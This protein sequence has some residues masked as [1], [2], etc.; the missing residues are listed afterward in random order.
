MH[1]T[2]GDKMVAI[3]IN[4]PALGDTIAAIP[5]LRRL[6]QAY[7]NKK[8]T[9]FSSKPFL[10][11]GHPLVHEVKKLEDSTEGYHVY[12]TFSNLLTGRKQMGDEHVEFRYSN[13]DLR[14][15]HAVSLG[16]TLTEA[17]MEM[18]L[19]IEK[20]RE[21]PFKDYVIIHPT[22]T[23]P[24]RTWA[25]EKWQA[26]VDMLNDAGIP[27]V[28]VG[29]DSKEGGT[30][31]TQKPVMDIN[32]RLGANLLN[33]PTND[34]AELRWMMNHRARAVVTMDSGILHIAGT[35]NV[36]IIQLS[37]SIDYR[38]RAPYR[39]G[40]Q[41][42]KYTYV[43]GGCEMCS[44]DMAS[45]V[46]EHGTIHGVPP[47]I[48][49]MKGKHFDE[50]HPTVDQVFNTVMDLDYQPLDYTPSRKTL[51]D[52]E[53]VKYNIRLVHLLLEDDLD[54]NRQERS[55]K[56]VKELERRG[57]EY[58]QV[59]NKRWTEQPPRETFARP[60]DFDR[61]P[62]RPSHYGN[63]RAFSD[64][65]KQYF[66]EDIDAIILCE[67][68]LKLLEDTDQIVD[69][70]NRAYR[71]TQEHG[72]DYFSLGDKYLL[73]SKVLISNTLE[74]H[75][76][77]E[78]IDRAIGTQ[79]IMFPQNIR[80]YLL[81]VYE[82]APWDCVDLFLNH[83]FQGKKKIG[84]FSTSPTSQW[85]GVSSIEGV[86]RVY[87]SRTKLLYLTPHLSTGGM[88]QFVLTRLLALKEQEDYDI[89][90]VEYT[91]YSN[92][93]T[94]QRD[95]IIDLLE[96]RFHT[97]GYLN[98]KDVTTRSNDL[99]NLIIEL[100][101]D[102]IHIDECPEAFDSFNKLSAGFMEWLYRPDQHWRIVETCHNIWFKGADKKFEP[103]A[104]LF[105]TP[106][107]PANSFK[108]NQAHKAVIEYPI[109]DL[110]PTVDQ[111][112]AAKAELN[113]DPDK[114]HILNIGLW[115]H[116]KNQAE[117]VNIAKI[118]NERFPGKYQF[119]FVGNQASNFQDYWQPIMY[120]LPDNIKVWG[121]RQDTDIFYT[122]SD[123]FLFNSTW[124]CNPLVLREAIGYGLLTFSRNLPQYL[125]MFT[126]Y[127]VEL[128]DSLQQNVDIIL[129]YL[130]SKDILQVDF[131]PP[132]NEL[133]RFG[134]EHL[135]EYRQLATLPKRRHIT[136]PASL[137][138]EFKYGLKLYCDSLTVGDWH[139][140][141]IVD[142][143]V[144]YKA[145]GLQEGYWYSPSPKWWAAWQVKVYRDGEIYQT[146]N[147]D[148][149]GQEVLVNFESSSLGDTLSWMGQM[150]AYKEQTGIKKLWVRTYKNWLFDHDWYSQHGIELIDTHD[151]TAQI[152]ISVGVFYSN[153]EPW[154]KDRHP[155]DWRHQPLGKIVTDQLGIDYVELRPKIAQQFQKTR[156][157][158]QKQIVI[159]T[160]STAQAKYW[161]NPHG[162]LEL[163]QWHMDQGIKVLHASKEGGGPIGSEQLPES[164]EEVA[165]ELNAAEYFI[166]ISSGLSWF[167]WALGVKVVM[168]SG[169]TPEWTEFEQDCLRIINK[170]KCWG[171]WS[172]STFDRGD[173][174]WC[175]SHKDTPRQ[176]ECTKL[177]E[178]SDVI[179]QIKESGWV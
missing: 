65:V 167:A 102:I 178:A 73:E 86:K 3:K 4:T 84:I 46:K 154:Q 122:A 2:S 150:L 43:D 79:M 99:T 112:L 77:V 89:H 51:S 52:M 132:S 95:Q 55:I 97:I 37:S 21:L 16:F 116:G 165:T 74:S 81:D 138:L 87:R 25:Q 98:S 29:R 176:F 134:Q 40:S 72:I 131:T 136:Q 145:Q 153:K 170:D 24:T 18:D 174:Q 126:P 47:Q 93:Y 158:N 27:V 70:I 35:T 106:Y 38:L 12:N 17:E 62:I 171:C 143:Q 110:R 123:I 44:S 82:N 56:Q 139:A 5:T 88:P 60:D 118:F 119:H 31:N 90:L 103:D 19:Y 23:W 9:V 39:N 113:M 92:T 57:I 34:P 68:D 15:F 96:D 159:A 50:C 160:Q 135:I 58:I 32:I 61:V 142:G 124:E 133:V 130:Q 83:N 117:A 164:L 111:K 10:F 30:Y 148:L 63:F 104:Y 175:P 125:D 127:I 100:K 144:F 26:L 94:V 36:N 179:T 54:S 59:W 75:G 155:N 157:T 177:I 108:D 169:F 41:N 11:E 48:K 71:A 162:W 49:C 42:Y 146:L 53:I 1:A 20:P 120:D 105:C 7:N 67:G 6:S 64:G 152:K 161:N 166:G 128:Q 107:H 115:T 45:N 172:F 109:I 69:R 85:D 13:M 28:A 121:E 168:I 163:T 33:D 8:L 140:D 66:T 151:I 137:R 173:W 156:M 129:T 101:P 147:L 14:Q 114:I 78:I 22:Y 91:Q 149:Q 76:D 141:F 80:E